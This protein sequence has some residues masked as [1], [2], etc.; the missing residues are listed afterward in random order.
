[1]D[2]TELEPG[3]I[4]DNT[5]LVYSAFGLRQPITGVTKLSSGADNRSELWE[6]R[7]R[8]DIIVTALA[9]LKP[10]FRLS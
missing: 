9:T 1:M 2:A 3:A 6:P 10:S 5:V 7:L 4:T 8:L